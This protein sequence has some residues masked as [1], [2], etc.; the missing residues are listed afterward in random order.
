MEITMANNELTKLVKFF[1]VSLADFS[2]FCKTL[3]NEEKNQFKAE[4]EK[5]DEKTE[6]V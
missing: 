5:W 4:V 3:T 2:A 6:F 1:N